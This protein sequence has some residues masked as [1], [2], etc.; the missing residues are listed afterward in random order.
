ME[1]AA[2]GVPLDSLV[3]RRVFGLEVVPDRRNYRRVSMA[4]GDD[5]P[6][7]GEC[8]TYA[9]SVVERLTET[10]FDVEVFVERQAGVP[11][12][13]T[14]VLRGYAVVAQADAKTMPE[15][16]CRAALAAV[17]KGRTAMD[18]ER[19]K[20]VLVGGVDRLLKA[21]PWL[22]GLTEEERAVLLSARSVIIAD[23]DLAGRIAAG[24]GPYRETKGDAVSAL[25]PYPSDPV[26]AAR[27]I[28]GAL[29]G[30]GTP[31]VEACHACWHLIGVGLSFVDRHEAPEA[32][33]LEVTDQGRAALLERCFLDA[34]PRGAVEVPWRLILDVAYELLSRW[35][36]RRGP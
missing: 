20:T 32:V 33:A 25:H 16:V 12:C 6:H 17:T 15:S 36:D 34:E 19:C 5:L 1:E 26:P 21:R 30:D 10:G 24:V 23:A 27:L 4:G 3:A 31:V 8:E 14:L 35:L 28:V 7:Y 11:S 29:R 2:V 13:Q 9:W 18:A 22:T